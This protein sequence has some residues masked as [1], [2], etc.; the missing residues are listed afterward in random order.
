MA[1]KTAP[2]RSLK[3]KIAK[4]AFVFRIRKKYAR[5][6]EFLPP[7][8]DDLSPLGRLRAIVGAQQKA[9]GPKP[10]PAISQAGG[11]PAA[12]A[13]PQKKQSLLSTTWGKL[14][15]VALV[16]LVLGIAGLYFMVQGIIA[17]AGGAG[18]GE[19][20]AVPYEMSFVINDTQV[21]T[22]GAEGQNQRNIYSVISYSTAN[23][24]NATLNM[25]VFPNRVPQQ[26]YLL[27]SARDS[28]SS[29]PEFRSTLASELERRGMIVNEMDMEQLQTLPEGAIVIIPSGYVPAELVKKSGDFNIRKLI[30]RGV[31]VMYIGLPFDRAIDE[32]GVSQIVDSS[33]LGFTFS[34]SAGSVSNL[35]LFDPRYS[36][37]GKAGGN[38]S[39]ST[40]YGALSVVKV[41]NGYII[42]FPQTLDG[43]WRGRGDLAAE[44]VVSVIKETAWQTPIT[45][46]DNAFDT[47]LQPNRTLFLFSNA[48]PSQDV[49]IKAYFEGIDVAG[50]RHGIMRE[51][52]AYK[53]ARG[54]IY[55]SEGNNVISSS[56][57]G[58]PVR[59]H[60]YLNEPSGRKKLT[61]ET[62]TKGSVAKQEPF[63]EGETNLNS[64]K[65]IDY[66]ARLKP[67]KYVIRVI[68]STGK[69]YAETSLNVLDIRPELL[70]ADFK[71]GDFVFGVRASD[72]RTVRIGKVTVSI[73]N[74]ITQEFSNTD[75]I[76][77]KVAGLTAGDHLFTFDFQGFTRKSFK[78]NYQPP[79]QFWDEP[80]FLAGGF[81]AI[82]IFG[83]GYL[84]RRPEKPM[85]SLDVPDFPPTSTKRIPIKRAAVLGLFDQ[86]NKDYYW[87][88]TP[89]KLEE[90]KGGFRKLS[91]QA[92]P[93]YIG[94]YNL[95]RILDVLIEEGAV[96]EDSGY[97]GLTKW[98]ADSGK[99]IKYLALS[100]ML[101]DI[102]VNNV[103][104]FSPIGATPDYDTKISIGSQDAYVHIYA[105]ASVVGKALATSALGR[106]FIVFHNEQELSLFRESLASVS[107]KVAAFKMQVQNSDIL[108]VAAND[109]AK[110]VKQL[111][112]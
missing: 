69:A 76:K 61:I 102:F 10:A 105:D 1:E 77:M 17:G 92:R 70:S 42:F 50:E 41:G 82:I 8:T 111:K 68:D 28:A 96:A 94:D 84:M 52:P 67:G 90:I 47:M 55:P 88:R 4:K 72:G 79:R 104:K 35:T 83:A 44:D 5:S 30:E 81:L 16:V 51:I 110:T 40:I 103:I 26:I 6:R 22:Y 43:G 87:A 108:L 101:R 74:S 7:K 75:T 78:L 91:Y 112:G 100:R 57:T 63:E 49:Y 34:P 19:K 13:A 25:K 27:V 106:T 54:E 24:T 56:V 107:P 65:S 48:Y 46:M 97:Y 2:K 39:A 45:E 80:M 18:A 93:I 20:V 60:V 37:T 14:A 21:L 109:F 89:L 23:I 85:F 71:S 73:D 31:V 53:F 15:V 33:H 36:V 95:E 11:K 32:S 38:A 62:V 59:L 64:V 98:E 58:L 3:V 9:S 12:G 66:D 86:V 99:S 29:Y